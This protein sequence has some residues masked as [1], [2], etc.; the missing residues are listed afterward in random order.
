MHQIKRTKIIWFLLILFFYFI[1]GLDMD[2]LL[3]FFDGIADPRVQGRCLHNLSDLLVIALLC[4][5]A[6]GEDFEDME[7]YGHQNKAFLQTFLSLPNG[8]PS[9]D[10]FR[11]FLA[12]WI[13][14]PCCRCL[15]NIPLC[16]YPAY[17]RNRC[18]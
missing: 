17:G 1:F 8:I 11:L 7:E 18:V 4:M 16:C 13:P 5:I 12:S 15:R 9:H 3:R 2:N 6:N 10:T 14:K